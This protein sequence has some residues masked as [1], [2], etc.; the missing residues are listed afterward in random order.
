[1]KDEDSACTSPEQ[2]DVQTRPSSAVASLE[3]LPEGNRIFMAEMDSSFGLQELMDLADEH[4]IGLIILTGDDNLH[5]IACAEVEDYFPGW[6]VIS[7]IQ[8]AGAVVLWDRDYWFV[9]AV[10][11]IH[12]FT[13]E[14]PHHDVITF[15]LRC[16]ATCSHSDR[17]YSG[18]HVLAM[19][20][21]FRSEADEVFGRD[22]DEKIIPAST[23]K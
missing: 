22:P 20:T 9:E 5:A 8:S 10:R 11:D 18:D 17:Y 16:F 12:I 1:M 7:H 4:R 21:S 19:V 13:E 3:K 6:G 23:P 15:K 14:R 2:E